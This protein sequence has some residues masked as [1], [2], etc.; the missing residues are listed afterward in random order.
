MTDNSNN[1]DVW[2]ELWTFLLSG[3]AQYTDADDETKLDWQYGWRLPSLYAQ[4]DSPNSRLRLKRLIGSS[5]AVY[6]W[7]AQHGASDTVRSRSAPRLATA[8]L[9]PRMAQLQLRLVPQFCH[10]P[11]SWC[12]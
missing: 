6:V 3:G 9:F 10:V 1:E 12:C 4:A 11:P 8:A 7:E 2:K 5:R